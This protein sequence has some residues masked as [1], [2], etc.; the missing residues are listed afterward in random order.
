MESPPDADATSSSD[1]HDND[2]T[3]SDY[4]AGDVSVSR[5]NDDKEVHCSQK[6]VTGDISDDVF[7]PGTNGFAPVRGIQM[8]NTGRTVASAWDG[9][10]GKPQSVIN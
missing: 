10:L 3:G 1:E 4:D 8:G 2:A 5:D 9:T 7:V 6:R